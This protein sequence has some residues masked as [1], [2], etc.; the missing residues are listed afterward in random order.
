MTTRQTALLNYH[1][2]VAAFGTSAKAPVFVI[3][4]LDDSVG[5]EIASN[6]Q[7]NCAEKRDA[8]KASSAYPAF[9]LVLTVKDANTLLGHGW[10]NAKKIGVIPEGMIPVILISEERCLVVLMRRE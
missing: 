6:Y 2:D 8:I 9:T 4:D 10:P 1:R 3:L 5:F 7:P